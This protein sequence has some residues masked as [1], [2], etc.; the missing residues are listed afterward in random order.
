M[1]RERRVELALTQQDLCR[2]LKRNTKFVSQVETGYTMLDVLEF[3]EYAKALDLDPK[4]LLG[5]LLA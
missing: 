4:R 5:R 3:I 1:L 2:K